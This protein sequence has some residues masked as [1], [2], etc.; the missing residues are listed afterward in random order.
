MAA[1]RPVPAE[2]ARV[3]ALVNTLEVGE[4]ERLR[5]PGALRDWLVG[6]GLLAAGTPVGAAD[7]ALAVELREGLRALLRANAGAPLDPAAV[8]A[9]NRV[10]A[11]LPLHVGF[12]AGGL[13]ALEPGQ[14]GVRGA[15]AGLL[16]DVTLARAR[17]SWPRLKAC[18][19]GGC[20]YVF[21]DRSRNRSGR[22]CSM[23]ACGNRSKARAYRRRR[24][25]AA[26][27]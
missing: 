15:L 24:G 26:R 16:A 2:L 25:A 18:A 8:A 17:G 7:L 27:S 23:R 11:G 9:V 14:A 10:A 3:Q 4:E 13:P 12:A 19:A 6:Q 1:E 22:W 5:D 20:Q 21:Y